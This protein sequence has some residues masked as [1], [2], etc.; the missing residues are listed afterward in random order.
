MNDITK[1]ELDIQNE[2]FDYLRTTKNLSSFY[3]DGLKLIFSYET[4]VAIESPK[5][6]LISKNVWSNTTAR[7][8][9]WINPDKSLR[10]D[11][12]VFTKKARKLLKLPEKEVNDYCVE[13][14][15]KTISM[16]SAMFSLFAKPEDQ[17]KNNEQRLRFYETQ[18]G[19]IR[20]HDWEE[21]TTEE[22]TKRLNA[23]DKFGLSG[24]V[25]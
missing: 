4:L 12:D 16:A 7:H 17:R 21:L 3:L 24:E 6:L 22:Q 1:T 8:L 19:F 11:N 25:A 10:L 5:G 18:N 9:Y 2:K 23:V 20:P 15:L 13:S 14:H